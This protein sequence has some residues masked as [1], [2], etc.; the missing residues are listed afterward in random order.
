MFH[1]RNM[2]STN[3]DNAKLKVDAGLLVPELVTRQKRTTVGSS[4]PSLLPSQLRELTLVIA[5]KV[6]GTGCNWFRVCV[7]AFSRDKRTRFR[8]KG[9]LRFRNGLPL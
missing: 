1:I 9:H 7:F 8:T 4:G 6:R 2:L 5:Q 3:T